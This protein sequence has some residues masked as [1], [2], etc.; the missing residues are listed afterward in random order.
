M[1]EE[2]NEENWDSGEVDEEVDLEEQEFLSQ[3]GRDEE[4]ISDPQLASDKGA[5]DE[6]N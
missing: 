3:L 2:E 4:E 1:S 6:P 5:L